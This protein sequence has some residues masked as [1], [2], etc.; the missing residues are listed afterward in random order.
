MVSSLLEASTPITT[1]S[2]KD[3]TRDIHPARFG[4]EFPVIAQT[5]RLDLPSGLT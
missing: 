3:R 1:S 5:L 4:A 2:A